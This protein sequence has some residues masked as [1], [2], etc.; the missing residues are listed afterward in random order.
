MQSLQLAALLPQLNP[1]IRKLC[2]KTYSPLPTLEERLSGSDNPTT[3]HILAAAS[4]L[5]QNNKDLPYWESVLAAASEVEGGTVFIEEALKHDVTYEAFERF[6]ATPQ[7]L[8]DGWLE[9]KAKTLPENVVIA[10]CSNCATQDGSFMHLPMMDFRL[11]PSPSSL[12]R[13]ATALNQIRLK[14]GAILES[15]R[16]YHYVGFSLF[17]EGDW[18]RFLAKNLLLSP[19]TDSRYIAHR[20]LEGVGSLRITS[21]P[22]KPQVPFVVQIL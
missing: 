1:K 5:R 9:E 4:E 14:D 2:L 11:E 10:L 7:Q 6:D 18:L 22:R 17:T 3:S 13:V 21:C 12:L 8:L 16:S 15:G 20:M 19:L